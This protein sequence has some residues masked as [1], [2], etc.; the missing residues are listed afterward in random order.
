M[1]EKWQE[2]TC[3]GFHSLSLLPG[4]SRGRLSV[5]SGQAV[6]VTRPT[7]AEPEFAV[8]A[9]AEPGPCAPERGC[10]AAGAEVP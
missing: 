10:Q 8:T 4:P 5:R 6:G 7:W 3:L 2:H 9:S 1:V